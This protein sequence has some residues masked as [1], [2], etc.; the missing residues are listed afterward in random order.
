MKLKPC[1]LLLPTAIL[2]ACGGGNGGHDDSSLINVAVVATRA[3]DYSS[4]AV[5]LVDTT[6]PFAAS[7]NENPNRNTS[8]LAVR[9]DGDH[10][11]LFAK[12]VV[13]KISRYD[14]ATLNT[15][16]RSVQRTVVKEGVSTC[17]SRWSP[18]H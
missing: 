8:D 11:F 4:G 7:N 6:P 10:Y 1:L 15:A 18:S 16:T 17:R 12:F 3:P 5:S 13:N 9:A 14:E 2:A